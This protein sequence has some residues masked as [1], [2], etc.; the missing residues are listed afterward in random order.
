LNY[1]Q[2]PGLDEASLTARIVAGNQAIRQ[3]GFDAV[4]CLIGTEPD[5]A[6]STIRT[7][8]SQGPFGLAMIGAGLRAPLEHAELLERVINVLLETCPGLRFCFNASPETT[9]AALRR[10]V[11]PSSQA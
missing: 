2:L 11:T 7:V 4:S 9:I 8:L 3:A 5:A 10:W 1:S 6:E